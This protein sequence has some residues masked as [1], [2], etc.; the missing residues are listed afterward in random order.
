MASLKGGETRYALLLVLKVIKNI[1][2]MI[3][4]CK[5]KRAPHLIL[6]KYIH[7]YA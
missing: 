3:P 6:V 2:M 1:Y 5:K 4:R 7:A